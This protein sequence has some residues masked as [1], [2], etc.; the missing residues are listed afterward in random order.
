MKPEEELGEVLAT[1][2]EKKKK[3]ERKL[4]RNNLV[5]TADKRPPKLMI[6]GP[7]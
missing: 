6:E 3:K 5:A 7:F 4:R 2:P 1:R